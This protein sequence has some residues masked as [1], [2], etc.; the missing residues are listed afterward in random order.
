MGVRVVVE[1]QM[2]GQPVHR[3]GEYVGEEP[4]PGAGETDMTRGS[5]SYSTFGR[6]GRAN[7]KIVL[8]DGTVIWGGEC[9]WWQ[10]PEGE[11]PAPGWSGRT[12]G[13]LRKP[14]E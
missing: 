13:P 11:E 8:D 2:D 14:P 7:P 3:A 9:W 10:I 6:K 5:A 4:Y 12:G 1:Y